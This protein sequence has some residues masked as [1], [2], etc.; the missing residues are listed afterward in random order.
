MSRFLLVVLAEDLG[1]PFRF[2]T[3]RD[4]AFTSIRC[5]NGVE[6]VADLEVISP[7]TL[8]QWMLPR[9]HRWSGRRH[10]KRN[11]SAHVRRIRV[12]V[13]GVNVSMTEDLRN[14]LCPLKDDGSLPERWNAD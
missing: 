13:K 2:P 8:E 1:H 11:S 5:V 10:R 14:R 3:T 7:R 6:C 4:G 9:D 12:Q